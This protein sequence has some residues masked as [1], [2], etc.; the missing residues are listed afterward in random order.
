LTAVDTQYEGGASQLS[1]RGSTDSEHLLNS[2]S[3]DSPARDQIRGKAA[4]TAFRIASR[5]RLL[6][7]IPVVA[8]A[9]ILIALIDPAPW[10][11]V[12]L[13]IILPVFAGIAIY[14][15]LRLKRRS[16]YQ[17]KDLPVDLSLTVTAQSA[18][19]FC[20]G[21]VESP[22]LPILVF[23]AFVN[24]AAIGRSEHR[25]VAPGF[26]AFYL[27]AMT[28]AGIFGWLPNST[29]SFLGLSH[30]FASDT[31]YTLCKAS[32]IQVLAVAATILGTR[33]SAL[34]EANLRDAMKARQE[35]LQTLDDRNRELV[36]MASS[37]AHELKNPLASINGIAQLLERGGGNSER[38]LKVL[39]SEIDRMRSTLDEFLN[40]SRPLG[41]L[42]MKLVPVANLIDELSL[43]HEEI[44]RRREIA[45]D[46]PSDLP[47]TTL[48]ADSRKLK[49]A[50][51]NLL[52][53]A[54]DATP[55]G[56]RVGWVVDEEGPFFR[57]GIMDTGAGFPP[58]F[59]EKATE[60]GVTT[61]ATESFVNGGL[62]IGR[63]GLGRSG[64]LKSGVGRGG[65]SGS[66]IGLAVCRSIAEQ[67]GG[68]LLI[69][70]QPQGGCQ[71]LICLPR[72]PNES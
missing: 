44:A 43:L 1:E 32:A 10:K 20:T 48:R 17:L 15:A 45:L 66:G 71:V 50:L 23:I 11:Y 41:D 61:K 68:K 13:A 16:T 38:R 28:L 53:N 72:T 56:G 49:Q 52:Q 65:V 27:W 8:T 24:G 12:A 22:L 46:K 30:E 63:A 39:R 9:I 64:I 33:I 29:P 5:L 7:V 19:I 26:L 59:I 57:I 40:F 67:H 37:I 18:L 42:T 70:N 62:G 14:D 54:L 69:E 25:W 58:D 4:S 3:G 36:G 55:P 21:A 6:L 2:D 35:V 47:F 34:F 51:V 60:L 31:I